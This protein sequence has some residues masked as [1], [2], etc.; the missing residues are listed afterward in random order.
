MFATY[1][2]KNFKILQDHRLENQFTNFKACYQL[3]KSLHAIVG[4]LFW[5]DDLVIVD[6]FLERI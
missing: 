5:I 6:K 3:Q 1:G 2:I 4:K